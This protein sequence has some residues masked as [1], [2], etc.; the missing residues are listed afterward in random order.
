MLTEYQPKRT[1]IIEEAKTIMSQYCAASKKAFINSHKE[2]KE[3]KHAKVFTQVLEEYFAKYLEEAGSDDLAAIFVSITPSSCEF[4]NKET[5]LNEY[6]DNKKIYNY[7]HSLHS[8]VPTYYPERSV[9]DTL[10]AVL[11]IGNKFIAVSKVGLAE[12]HI[13]SKYVVHYL[14]INESILQSIQEDF[15]RM[16]L[17]ER[18]TNTIVSYN[19]NP[20]SEATQAASDKIKKAL[21]N[22]EK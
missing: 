5:F 7:R 19:M 6:A 13:S 4:M 17:M 15:G 10:L 2:G 3:R 14:N 12:G 1:L 9:V 20:G 16:P 18:D 22:A 21:K 8:N 11:R